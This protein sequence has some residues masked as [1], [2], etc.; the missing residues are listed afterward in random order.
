METVAIAAVVALGVVGF[1]AV[2]GCVTAV[3]ALRAAAKE[4]RRDQLRLVVAERKADLATSASE[5]AATTFVESGNDEDGSV[6][7]GEPS[8]TGRQSSEM[9]QSLLDPDSADDVHTY[10]TMKSWGLDPTEA[11][12]RAYWNR[13]NEHGD[14]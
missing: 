5:L 14:G 12:D 9:V 11:S 6:E 7:T 10:R 4:Q 2:I 8:L 3:G 1:A 13:V